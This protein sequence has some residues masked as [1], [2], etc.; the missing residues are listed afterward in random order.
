MKLK[1]PIALGCVTVLIFAAGCAAADSCTDFGHSEMRNGESAG[2]ASGHQD[3][4]GRVIGE[5]TSMLDQRPILALCENHGSETQHE[6]IR[7]LV[8]DP[9]FTE[10]VDDIVVEFA[11]AGQQHVIDRYVG[12]EDVPF[13]ELAS[14]WRDTGAVHMPWESPVY[15]QFFEHVRKVNEELAKSGSRRR[16]RLL[17]GDPP[18]DWPTIRTFDELMA[19]Y[20]D[21][22]NERDAH[23][24]RVIHRE[25]LDRG[26]RALVLAGGGHLTRRNLWDPP[27]P[28]PSPDTT[29]VHL[30][31]DAP[32]S[33]SVVLY[34]GREL[35]AGTKL[36]ERFADVQSPQLLPTGARR[37][38]GV[39]AGMFST[40]RR[41]NVPPDKA[42][43]FP[44]LAATDIA[45]AVLFLLPSGEHRSSVC[46]LQFWE[47][48]DLTKI[49]RRR[50]IAHRGPITVE[51]LLQESAETTLAEGRAAESLP[52]WQRLVERKPRVP[53]FHAGL[54]KALVQL[55]QEQA[56]VVALVQAIELGEAAG[57][58]RVLSWR[59]LLT[60]LAGELLR[61]ENAT[62][63][64]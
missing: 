47:S 56:A 17:G 1:H 9:R 11:T 7:A 32:D 44:G 34:L 52:I 33:T 55:H 37:F 16:L 24:A 51:D 13:E 20:N 49:N 64:E 5:L 3:S 54:G 57:D 19:Y 4:T 40:V 8:A 59:R 35:L 58:D 39:P 15:F 21:P 22:E 36:G 43:A 30:E 38:K 18:I 31:R 48:M 41:Y 6:F 45:D 28:N 26:R 60:T 2:D 27:L 50:K 53:G 42:L 14:A 46:G 62:A 25:V 63:G 29:V 23:M 12:G 10:R 61:P